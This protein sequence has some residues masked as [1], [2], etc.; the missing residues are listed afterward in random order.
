[1]EYFNAFWVG[2]LICV[3]GQLLIDRTKLTPARIMVMYVTAGVLLGAL[4]LYQ[5]LLDF[6]GSGA[7][8]PLCGFGNAL[9]QG[10][11]KAVDEKGF[12][13]IFSGGF[14]AGAAGIGAAVCFG[15]IAALLTRPKEK[16]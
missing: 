15:V 4:G 3:I 16:R 14:T 2:G 11:K 9:A 13:G 10:V 6:A 8:V 7:G 12:L 5:P 1:M